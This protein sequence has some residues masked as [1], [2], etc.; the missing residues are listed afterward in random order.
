MLFFCILSVLSIADADA[1]LRQIAVDLSGE[2]QRLIDGDEGL[3]TSALPGWRYGLAPGGLPAYYLQIRALQQARLRIDRIEVKGIRLDFERRQIYRENISTSSEVSSP[4]PTEPYS[5]LIN[6]NGISA[7][8][9]RSFSYG[10]ED[11]YDLVLMPFCVDDQTDEL[12]AY[13][14]ITVWIE[15][16]SDNGEAG[17]EILSRS[18]IS[19]IVAASSRGRQSSA[20]A[21]QPKHTING[22]QAGEGYLI[23]TNALLA[24]S[25]R[26]FARWKQALGYNCRLKL[27]EEIEAEESGCDA[28]EQLREYLKQAYQDGLTWVLLGGDE[29]VVPYRLLFPANTN[30]SIPL[31]YLHPSDLYFAD[32]TGEWEVDGDGIWGEPYHDNPD[33]E[34]ELYIGRVLVNTP[35]EVSRWIAKT[36]AYEKGEFGIAGEF[37][38]R[39]LITSADQ[40]R[41]WNMGS[42]QDSLIAEYFPAS[43]MPDRRSM[44]ELPSGQAS[45][46][47][48][49]PAYSFIQKF[50]EGWNLA[51]ILA[52][53]VC[54]G[55]VSM[56]SGYNQWPKTYVWVGSGVE[57]G[58]GYLDDL[59]NYGS[60]GIIYSIAC[61]QGG[62][63]G[64]SS[65]MAEEM[66]NLEERGAAAFIG[67]TRY[68]WVASSYLLA[69]QF[70]HGLYNIDSRLGPANTYSKLFY[71]VYRDLNYGLNLFGDPSLPVW[72]GD[73]DSLSVT[74]PQLISLGE[75]SFQVTVAREGLPAESVLV[76][77]IKQDSCL[78]RGFTEISG[79]ISIHFDT[80]I[81]SGV[82]LTA[83]QSGARPY[84]V[85]LATTL[86]LDADDNNQQDFLPEDFWLGQNYP[87]PAN[88]ATV[89]GY[90]LPSGGEATLELFNLLGQ[91]MLA[92]E[93]KGLMAGYHEFTLALDR[94]PSGIY[95]Y[96]L[97]SGEESQCK[98]LI[99]LK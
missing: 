50:S 75:N 87:N 18:D 83:S 1:E 52:H 86:V 25:F 71:S 88:P 11:Y 32:L 12:T 31:T 51:I 21:A 36:I 97:L 91:R 15:A 9:S 64:Q 85:N 26:P 34:P 35:Q 42:G 17:F 58:V 94:L 47:S 45:D 6:Y 81:D 55:F 76:T 65:C 20:F 38:E 67:Y 78:F 29:T 10:G 43:I 74:H 33:L 3:T 14:Q 84:Q 73:P 28:A 4:P 8:F 57:S 39:V 41:D 72:T 13:S 16:L 96:R 24:E 53:G 23:I 98:K 79:H 5:S 61:S 66:L 27:M 54:E 19:P 49:P 93:E 37:A 46:P 62:F 48:Q 56:S 60:A 82:V 2:Y 80:G 92:I 7:A 68:G 63:D 30:E 99:L 95:F 90:N 22:G 77:I 44:A 40:M 70:V 89:I 59:S 69:E